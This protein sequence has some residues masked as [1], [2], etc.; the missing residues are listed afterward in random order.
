MARPTLRLVRPDEGDPLT[1]SCSVL[2]PDPSR[3][4]NDRRVS[5]FGGLPFWVAQRP[6]PGCLGCGAPLSFLGQIRSDEFDAGGGFARLFSCFYCF[7]CAPWWDVGGKGFHAEWLPLGGDPPL[8]AAKHSPLRVRAVEPL[9]LRVA[10]REDRPSLWD[11]PD[12]AT[13]SPGQRDLLARQ[14]PCAASKMGG[15]PAWL[16]SPQKPAC[17]HCGGDMHFLGQFSSGNPIR[18]EFGGHGRLFWFACDAG[19]RPDAI[20]LL[21]QDE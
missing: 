15:W 9:A 18:A 1:R 17:R 3:S 8:L 21:V 5:K 13:L 11:H 6:W 20:S 2:L 12:A 10:P 4:P 14:G 19:C 16:Q 7:A